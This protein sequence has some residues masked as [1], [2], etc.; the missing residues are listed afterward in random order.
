MPTSTKVPPAP[1]PNAPVDYLAELPPCAAARIR[2]ARSSVTDAASWRDHYLM[3]V[4]AVMRM[5]G[6]R[7]V[8]INHVG[9][10]ARIP[11]QWAAIKLSSGLTRKGRRDLRIP[12][13]EF[14]PEGRFPR[15]VEIF[16]DYEREWR[17]VAA[18]EPAAPA[19]TDP[20]RNDWMVL[21]LEKP[22]LDDVLPY[23]HRDAPVIE[24]VAEQIS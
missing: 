7:W 3:A 4:I 17:P 21:E 10:P 1:D 2:N 24:A 15:R 16:P 20:S 8:F 23:Q 14:W 18:I 12:A 19:A 6:R 9:V 13:A 5:H 11:A 22:D